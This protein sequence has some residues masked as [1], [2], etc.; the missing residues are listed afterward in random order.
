MRSSSRSAQSLA[1]IHL[2]AVLASVTCACGEKDGEEE[3]G[4]PP[5][6]C[7]FP[8]GGTDGEATISPGSP[9][10][11]HEVGGQAQ[12]TMNF[13]YSSPLPWGRDG[14]LAASGCGD[15]GLLSWIEDDPDV[16][17]TFSPLPGGS[18]EVVSSAFTWSDGVLFYDDDCAARVLA[19]SNPPAFV[20]YRRTGV[21]VWEQGAVLELTSVLGEEPTGVTIVDSDE[22]ADGNHYVFATASV[23]AGGILLRGR[24]GP[25][26][27]D[28]W[29]F[30]EIPVPQATDLFAYRVGPDG[31]T[32]AL[33]RNTE[34]PCDP[35]NVDFLHGTLAEG[36]GAWEE[37]VVQEGVWGDPTDQFVESADMGFD[38]SGGF[39]IAAHFVE[40]VV[41]G[42]YDHAELR[43]YGLVEGE[44]CEEGIVGESDQYQGGDGTEYTGADPRI[45]IDGADHIHVVFRD[46]SVWHD[47]DG[48]Q[49]EIRGQVRYAVRSGDTWTTTTLLSQTGQSESVQP[50]EGFS[51]PLL[52]VSQDGGTVVTAGIRFTWETD[53]IYND[54]QV[55]ATYA[56]TAITANVSLP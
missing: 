30:E 35:C 29:S 13:E 6:G 10:V 48:W 14:V 3:N 55:T 39:Y 8:E 11:L 27:A 5:G 51:P 44:W 54:T 32:H 40:R 37:E 31:A 17:R 47:G 34:Y 16:D 22:G 42:S 15:F 36:A 2:F 18:P 24:R 21:D 26:A 4:N 1:L 25:G 9:E 19:F 23:D 38:S 49:N 7:G 50:L 33:Y 43:I 20:E 41:T 56:V 52:A 53:S 28:N 46:Q 12:N 45:I